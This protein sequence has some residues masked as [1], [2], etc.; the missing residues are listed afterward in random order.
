[1]P[2]SKGQEDVEV[3]EQDGE[4]DRFGIQSVEVAAIILGTLTKAGQ[5]LALKDLARL[6]DMAPGK[7]HRY[8]VSL[9]RT[10]LVVQDS[11][12]WHYGI[13]PAA[14]SLGLAGLRS[15][16]VVRSA[17]EF[18]P[19]L[20]DGTQ[21]TALLAVWSRLGPVV[22][23]LEESSRPAFMNV[24]VGSILPIFRTATG[25][26]FA[27][28]LPETE[29]KE[30]MNQERKVLRRATSS[31]GQRLEQIEKILSST[32]RRGIAAVAGDLVPGVTAL[33]APIFD[34]RGRIAAVVGLLGRS[35]DLAANTGGGPAKLLKDT[36]LAISR[37]LGHS[38][39]DT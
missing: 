3:S 5:P 9:T 20:R 30:I 8:L 25:R 26:V 6:S 4:D 7:V 16:D 31:S 24:R 18:L 33:S 11:S 13:G 35:E 2:A 15:V 34:H 29:V 19:Q 38:P 23:R 37:R 1:L 27:A 21:E 32:K 39:T 12:D 10:E 22:I 28:Y 14:I 36:A 17:S